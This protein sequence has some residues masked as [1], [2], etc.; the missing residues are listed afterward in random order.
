MLVGTIDD[1]GTM[2]L[3]QGKSLIFELQPVAD[4]IQKIT[5]A[6]APTGGTFKLAIRE[7]TTATISIQATAAQVQAALE[8]LTV[9]GPGNVT[10]TGGPG[11]SMPWYITMAGELEGARVLLAHVKAVPVQVALTGDAAAFIASSIVSPGGPL[12]L[13]DT[14]TASCQIRT[15]FAD[16]ANTTL[17]SVPCTVSSTSG[18]LRG[19]AAPDDTDD[20]VTTN[21]ENLRYEIEA[22]NAAGQTVRVLDGPVVISRTVVRP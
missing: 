13:Q 19:E 21:V 10:V 4:A 17:L 1:T 16:F 22:T 6:G 12:F 20:V 15:D 5:V 9:I 2:Y 3:L 11:P 8:S 14:W 7:E 18:F